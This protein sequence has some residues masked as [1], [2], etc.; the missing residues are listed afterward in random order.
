MY[1]ST[2]KCL[3]SHISI[4]NQ[5]DYTALMIAVENGN[6]SLVKLLLGHGADTNIANTNVRH[7]VG[8]A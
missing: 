6:E 8:C 1:D 2:A 7:R 3:T 4:L 5:S